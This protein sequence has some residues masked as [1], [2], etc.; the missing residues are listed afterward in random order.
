[1]VGACVRVRVCAYMC[2]YAYGCVKLTVNLRHLGKVLRGPGSAG[3]GLGVILRGLKGVLDLLGFLERV[4]GA[5]W[6]VWGVLGSHLGPILGCLGGAWG[7]LEASRM[8]PNP[9]F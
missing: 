5:S 3:R 6:S 8:N 9:T 7:A 2:I 1:M 4:L